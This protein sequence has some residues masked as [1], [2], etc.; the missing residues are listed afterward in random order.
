VLSELAN[1]LAEKYNVDVSRCGEIEIPPDYLEELDRRVAAGEEAKIPTSITIRGKTIPV[2]WWQT[3]SRRVR[4]T[5]EEPAPVTE[6]EPTSHVLE[7]ATA[8][9][10]EPQESRRMDQLEELLQ[11]LRERKEAEGGLP[12]GY[13]NPDAPVSQVLML[14]GRQLLSQNGR[15]YNLRGEVIKE[16]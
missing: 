11:E 16:G 1:Y 7:T 3:H 6:E 13:L 10:G 5:E 9:E 2:P 4:P 14:G 12:A 8:E 15:L